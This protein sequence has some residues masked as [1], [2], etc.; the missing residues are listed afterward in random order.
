MLQILL[1]KNVWK[2]LVQFQFKW[3]LNSKYHRSA[4][5][6]FKTNQTTPPPQTQQKNPSWTPSTETVKCE[7]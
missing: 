7:G 6:L 4:N 1:W 2:K 3:N 5:L